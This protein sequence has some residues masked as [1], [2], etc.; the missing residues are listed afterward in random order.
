VAAI[1]CGNCGATHDTVADVRTCFQSFVASGAVDTG[2]GLAE[3]AGP[4]AATVAEG[5]A[6]RP[7]VRPADAWRG[8][9]ALG[10][11]LVVRPGQA[12]PAPWAG[13][14]VVAIDA[15]H[16]EAADVAAVARHWSARRRFVVT[17]TGDL[18]HAVEAAAVAGRAP[19]ELEPGFTFEAERLWYLLNDHAVDDRLPGGARFAPAERA[20]ALGCVADPLADVRLPDGRLAYLDGG[21][22]APL[23]LDHP[24]VATISLDHGALR[25]LEARAPSADLAP[26]Q[27]A[28]VGHVGGAARIIAPAGSGKTRVLTERARHLLGGWGV[29]AGALCLVAFNVRAAEEMRSRTLDQPGLHVRTLNSLG[30]AI[31]NGS[32]PFLARPD[33]RRLTTIDEFDVR[34]ILETLVRFPR[35]AGTDPV[36]PWLEAL[37]AVRLGLQDPVAVEEL[38]DGDVEGFAD[39]LPRYRAELARRGVL[40][41][42]EQITTA[43]ERLVG[44]P[45]ARAAAQ[46][47]CR[48]LLVDEFQDLAPAHLLLVRLLC[49]PR[50]D[51]FG[52]GDDDQ[53]IYG[54]V[55]ANPDWLVRF[56][57][58]FPGAHSHALT[59]NYRC[60][61]GVVTAASNLLTRNTRRVP[62]EIHPRPGRAAT[63]GDLRILRTADPPASTVAEVRAL[64]DGAVAPG[65]VAVLTRVNV[66]LLAVQLGLAAVGVPT[67]APVDVSLLAR[68][69]VR[70]ALAWLHL[71]ADPARLTGASIA[72]AARRPSRGLSPRVVEWMGEQRDLAGLRRLAGRLSTPRDADKVEAF[73]ADVARLAALAA[74]GADT[75]ALLAAVRDQ[76]GLGITLE[77]LDRSRR[78]LDRSAHGDDLAAMLAVA[79]LH[80]DPAT[81]PAWLRAQLERAGTDRRDD[82]VHLAT[83]HK[84]KGREWPHV[85]VHDATEGLLPHRLANDR[86][87]E[88]RV[89]HVAITRSSVATVVV[90]DAA[91]PS[92]FLDELAEPGEPPRPSRNA[93]P[94]PRRV[95][96]GAVVSVPSGDADPRITAAL[97]S[98]RRE[99]AHRDGVPAYVVLP[100]KAVDD[101]ARRHPGS[102]ADLARCH[103]IGPMK[104]ERY[105]DEILAALDAAVAER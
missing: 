53:T 15:D 46:R 27:L 72:D 61:P 77:T 37:A 65:D 80:P 6:P 101:I 31:V 34:R 1:T 2:T 4:R 57:D 71:A 36:A 30:L 73:V 76:L 52:V 86:E 82:G 102:L 70:A 26:D 58:W 49:A 88:R 89:F 7:I 16:L 24:A 38:F 105:G 59:V 78:D 84:V 44:E 74:D 54:Y 60:A 40:D 87:E 23:E 5:P 104:L 55:G 92:T 68:S 69:G 100:D 19:W 25:P 96:P 42:D 22:L 10:R 39:V 95:G 99:R 75:A 11:G 47:A 28:A 21:P 12:V 93:D 48:V 97:K 94:D 41:F 3:V 50:F 63:E 98:W 85:I 29:P 79:H 56:S 62:K 64:L 43:L 81:F 83:V 20:V 67:N 66:T 17:L 45:A 14:P 90:S 103:G 32:G 9:D 13:A 51:C 8:P 91:A 18:D 33:A 35:R